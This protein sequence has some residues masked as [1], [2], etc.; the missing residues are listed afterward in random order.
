MQ[1]R[2]SLCLDKH[3]GAVIIAADGQTVIGAG[4]N[5]PPRNDVSL[6]RC[7]IPMDKRRKYPSDKSCCIHAEQRA[8]YD[9]LEHHAKSLPGAKLYYITVDEAGQPR[10]SSRPWC[11]HCSKLALDV[12][13]VK[14]YLWHQDGIRGYD[15][16]E[17]NDLSFASAAHDEL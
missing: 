1:A 2:Q 12:G 14:F 9:A 15:T 11:T 4:F 6:R 13:L 5:G 16:A 17:Y 10:R 3:C 7:H 8:I